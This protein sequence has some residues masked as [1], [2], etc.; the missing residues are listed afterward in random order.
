M[1]RVPQERSYLIAVAS[2]HALVSQSVQTALTGRLFEAVAVRWPGGVPLPRNPRVS[3]RY[4]AG[5]LLSDLERAARLRAAMLLI[6]HM[7]T[8]W[9]VL[10]DS[11]RGPLWGAMY[12]AGARLVLPSSVSL[13][14]LAAMLTQ[15]ADGELEVNEAE[16]SELI[17]AWHRLQA[18]RELLSVRMGSLTP[19]ERDVLGLLHAGETV[20]DIAAILEVSLSTV[21]SQVKSILRK[22]EVNSQLAAVADYRTMLDL[23]QS[24]GPSEEDPLRLGS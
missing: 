15:L 11:P 12:D 23:E 3:S 5:L 17:E 9:L 22:L 13:D 6:T 4:D 2:Q 1:A 20:A 21:R 7:P 18:E 10:T 19:R 8:P 24:S 14:E 16:R